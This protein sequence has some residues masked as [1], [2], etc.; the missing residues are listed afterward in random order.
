MPHGVDWSSKPIGPSSPDNA[1]DDEIARP[2]LEK[3]NGARQQAASEVM[4][5][6][7]ENA[8]VVRQNSTTAYKE[9]NEKVSTL[10]HDRRHEQVQQLHS[11]NNVPARKRNAAGS[12][13]QS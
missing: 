11:P 13:H 6:S 3:I 12:Q 5:A 1:A 10:A 4:P 7:R 8:A 2:A 9:L